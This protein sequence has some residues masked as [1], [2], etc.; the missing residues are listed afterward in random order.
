MEIQS[1]TFSRTKLTNNKK[2]RTKEMCF[3]MNKK[4]YHLIYKKISLI[5]KI[6]ANEKIFRN[7]TNEKK[8]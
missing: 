6:N 3:I 7:K 8:S 5:L 2:K 4:I 1:T